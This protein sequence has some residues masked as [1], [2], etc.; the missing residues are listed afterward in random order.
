MVESAH[1]AGAT[2]NVSLKQKLL[3]DPKYEGLET[4]SFQINVGGEL[5]VE[6]S[7]EVKI[8]FKNGRFESATFPFSGVYTR[9]GWRILADIESKIRDIE[10]TKKYKNSPCQT[11]T[12]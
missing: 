6:E 1:A 10:N 12:S 9:N 8:V 3:Y 2:V 7:G 11:P 5:Y 4:Y